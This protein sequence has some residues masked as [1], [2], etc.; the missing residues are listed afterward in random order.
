MIGAKRMQALTHGRFLIFYQAKWQ[1]KNNVLFLSVVDDPLFDLSSKQAFGSVKF[2][3]IVPFSIVQ[4]WY[5]AL[6]N[7]VIPLLEALLINP[8]LIFWPELYM[9]LAL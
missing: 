6:Y 2:L 9:E 1:E 4:F 7:Y 3:N 8:A 5:D